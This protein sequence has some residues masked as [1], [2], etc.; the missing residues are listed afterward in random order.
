M[1]VLTKDNYAFSPET[2]DSFKL[3]DQM[4][5]YYDGTTTKVVPL[6]IFKRCPI[7]YDKYV[8]NYGKTI[9]ISI[10]VCPLSLA[11]TIFEGKFIPTE[12]FVNSCLVIKCKDDDISFPIVTPFIVDNS[13]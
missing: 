13:G 6:W 9:D 12:K 5:C 10:V 8:E 7:I 4:L 3:S 1:R 2:D 11:A